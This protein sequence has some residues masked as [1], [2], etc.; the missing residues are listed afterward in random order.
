MYKWCDKNVWTGL[1]N[2]LGNKWRVY[3][4]LTQDRKFSWGICVTLLKTWNCLSIQ[5][6]KWNQIHSKWKYIGLHFTGWSISAC[7]LQW[8]CLRQAFKQENIKTKMR[9]ETINSFFKHKGKWTGK[10]YYTRWF[11]FPLTSKQ[12]LTNSFSMVSREKLT[13]LAIKEL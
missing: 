6:A 5:K 8:T 7:C 10:I 1:T 2:S 3:P 11:S 13:P 12:K 9:N 4:L